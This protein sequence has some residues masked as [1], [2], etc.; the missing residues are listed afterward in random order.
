MCTGPLHKATLT[1]SRTITLSRSPT[2]ALNVS[3]FG[4]AARARALLS[5][6]LTAVLRVLR[7]R[8]RLAPGSLAPRL[9]SHR[10]PAGHKQ[11]APHQRRGPRSPRQAGP[12]PRL[13]PRPTAR[14]QTISCPLH[15]SIRRSPSAP[16]GPA[17]VTPRRSNTAPTRCPEP[18]PFTPGPSPCGGRTVRPA[19]PPKYYR[20]YPHIPHGCWRKT[21][22]PGPPPALAGNGPPPI[23]PAVS[24]SPIRPG[25][26][27]SALTITHRA[28]GA[29]AAS[30]FASSPCHLTPRVAP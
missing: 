24:V 11:T 7:H 2:A 30:G 25:M 1:L 17:G 27:A 29:W 15:R 13:P 16:A 26:P 5:R 14:A 22:H 21:R 9:A 6:T 4:R 23:L 8:L 3:S 10:G 12:D 20:T 19:P 28:L 18:S